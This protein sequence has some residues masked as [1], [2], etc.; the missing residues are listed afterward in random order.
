MGASIVLEN[1]HIVQHDGVVGRPLAFADGQ[2]VS[3]SEDAFR[4]DLRDHLIFPGLI[5][6]HDHVQLNSVPPLPHAQPFPNSYAWIDAFESYRQD[7]AVAAAV[8]VPS[9]ARHWQGGLKNLLAGV[10]TVAHHD[11]WHAV[12]DDP[13]FPVGLLRHFGWCHSLGLGEPH[14]D[15]PPRYGPPVR[16]SF[17]ATPT[18]QPW[19]IHL[20]EGTDAVARGELE[21]LDALGCLAANTVLVHGVGLTGPDVERVIECGAAVV[22]CP[23]SN[24]GMLGRTLGMSA[25]RRLFSAGRLALGSDS[26]LTGS[27]DLLD[28]LRV[29]ASHSS[30]SSRELLRLVTADASRILGLPECGGLSAGLQADCIVVR[31]GTDPYAT[32]LGT[33]RSAIRAVVRGGVPMIADP[34]FADW[35]SYC[36]VETVAVR[37]DGNAK[38]MARKLARPEITGLEPGLEIV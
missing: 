36:A 26:R 21:R 37:L 30:L 12:L 14:G 20:A 27:R 35:F 10:T 5:N 18:N 15:R 34:D 24:L 32:L 19:M 38:L 17:A 31:A 8:E 2:V 28:E 22:W 9:A 1:A 11:P 3:A 33:A 6:A 16:P 25:V 4:L 29:A 7:P 23:A 13:D